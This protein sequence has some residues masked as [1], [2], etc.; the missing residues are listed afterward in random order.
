MW[1][2]RATQQTGQVFSPYISVTKTLIAARMGEKSEL[3]DFD[4]GMALG[5]G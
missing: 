2:Q 5:A 4:S 3:C 1:S